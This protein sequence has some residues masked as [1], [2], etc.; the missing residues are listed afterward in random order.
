VRVKLNVHLVSERQRKGRKREGGRKGREE[1]R[2]GRR[3]EGREERRKE[4][5]EEGKEGKN[6]GG[7]EEGGT[8]RIEGAAP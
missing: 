6:G 4:E 2:E 8:T 3:K 5:R 1:V 7:K